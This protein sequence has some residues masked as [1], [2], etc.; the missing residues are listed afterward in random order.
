MTAAVNARTN[1][2]ASDVA[3]ELVDILDVHIL[4][5]DD[6]LVALLFCYHRLVGGDASLCE[7]RGVVFGGLERLKRAFD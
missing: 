6:E 2:L 4:V 1:S 5:L 7:L 3:A